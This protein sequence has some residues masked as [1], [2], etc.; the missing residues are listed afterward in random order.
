MNVEASDAR[1]AR[2]AAAIA[3]PART[4]MLCCLMDGHA[5]TSTELAAVAEV[6][7]S[8]ASVHLA[9]LKE[10]RLVKM[11]PQGKHRYYSLAGAEIGKAL[12][13]LMVVA[14]GSRQDFVPS[15][16]IRLRA[17]RT[18]Y[19]HMAGQLGVLLHDRLSQLRWLSGL[20]ASDAYDLTARGEGELQS[21]GVDVG[22]ARALRRRFAYACLDWSE[23]RPHVGGA[24]G[25]ALLDLALRRKWVI[26]DLDSRILNVTPAGR[27]ELKSR[28]GVLI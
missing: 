4:R 12:E 5:R 26:S 15:T 7:P 28:F 6:T 22:A 17:A 19:D 16:P 25:A 8:T 18:C 11:V 9:K 2:I 20:P 10:G 13:S 3:E 21:I 24:L 1:L 27:R 23:R 14:G